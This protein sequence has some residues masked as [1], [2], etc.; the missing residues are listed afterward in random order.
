MA[1]CVSCHDPHQLTIAEENCLTCH[2]KGDADDI[3]ISRQSHDGSGDIAKGIKA[4]IKANADLLM[5]LMADY[6]RDVAGKGLLYDG[7]RFPYFFADANGDGRA[8]EAGG[9]LVTYNA[10]TPRLLKAAFNWKV[11]DADPGIHV[12]NPHYALELLHDSIEDLAGSLDKDMSA[13]NIAR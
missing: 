7:K 4:D 12:H 5:T 13:F 6:A 11:V 8:D 2:E 9:K 1:T 10:F 3:R